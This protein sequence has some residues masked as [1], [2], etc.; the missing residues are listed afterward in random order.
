MSA[1]IS[2]QPR[3]R[4]PLATGL[5][6]AGVVVAAGALGF[7][8][9]QSHDDS[10]PA[11]APVLRTPTLQDYG[12]Y[13]YYHGPN[14]LNYQPHSVPAPGPN[15]RSLDRHLS[16]QPAAPNSR[17][18]EAQQQQAQQQDEPSFPSPPGGKT[19]LGE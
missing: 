13:D 8:W 10:A 3:H 7:A 11:Q 5:A 9:D 6:I 2:T 4:V 19:Q 15:A 18:F 17:S 1:T 16:F 12:M 14:A